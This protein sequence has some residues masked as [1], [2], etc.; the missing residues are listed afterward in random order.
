MEDD[1]VLTGQGEW[2]GRWRGLRS[3]RCGPGPGAVAGTG[4]SGQY[5]HC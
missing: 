4:G 3:H 2:G 1:K 5:N